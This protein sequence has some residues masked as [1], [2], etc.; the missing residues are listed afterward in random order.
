MNKFIIIDKSDYIN[1]INLHLG[2]YHP[3]RGFATLKEFE[4]IISKKKINNINFTIPINLFCSKI[5]ANNFGLGDTINLKYKNEIIGSLVLESKFKIDKKRILLSLFGTT[6]K[7]HLG[8]N[9]Y[10][11]KIKKNFISLGG[12]VH[13]N[14]NKVKKFFISNNFDTMKKLEKIKHRDVAFSTRNIPHI[15]HNLIQKKIIE[16]K[17]ELTIFLILS[18]KNK[19][20]K[21]ILID[22]YKAL[23]NNKIFKNINILFIYLPTFFA[24]PKEAFFQ[25]KIFENMKFKS[26][27]VGRD[28]AGYK[29]FYKKFNSQEIFKKIKSKIKIIK[30][31]EP[32]LCNSCKVPIINKYKYKK[33]CPLC[34]GKKLSELNGTDIKILIKKKKKDILLGL[35][36]PSVFNF[37]KKNNFTL[38]N[39]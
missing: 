26:F 7:T 8:V 34:N 3:L 23:K 1:A 6:N 24:G 29:S 5:K 13:V 9:N 11:K 27:Y 33:S 18:I 22:S 39:N 14:Y 12:R 35:L 2:L 30:L 28:H 25:G 20:N 36:D 38:L 21:K 16:S 31:N 37:F 10:S 17:K 15:G 32:M 4:S 19:Y